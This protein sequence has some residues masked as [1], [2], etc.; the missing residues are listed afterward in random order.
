[1]PYYVAIKQLLSILALTF[2]EIKAF[3]L[4]SKESFY[5]KHVKYDIF[6]RSNW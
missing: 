3:T 6:R 4:V 5:L 2:L 1:M